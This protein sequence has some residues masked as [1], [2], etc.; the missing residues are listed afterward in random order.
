[1]Q[2]GQGRARLA[3]RPDS[4]PERVAFKT[5]VED[6]AA[7]HAATVPGPRVGDGGAYVEQDERLARARFG[8][9]DGHAAPPRGARDDGHGARVLEQV[10]RG[11]NLEFVAGRLAVDLGAGGLVEF[12]SALHRRPEV[13]PA[14]T[15]TVRV[16]AREVVGAARVDHH[17]GAA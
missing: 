14:P 16:L 8:Y 12:Q 9:E 1:M 6:G 5:D 13:A 2:M 10:D 7:A 4:E 11:A 3:E 17:G 15:A